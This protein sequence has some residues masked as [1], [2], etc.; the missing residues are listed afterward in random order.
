[1]AADPFLLLYTSGTT[2]SPKAAP[3][4]GHTM[5]SNARL[6]VPEHA[7]GPDDLV[8]SAA[9]FGHLFA[10]YAIELA[11]CAGAASVLL[12][13][14]SPPAFAQAIERH[15]ATHLFAGPAHIAA[16][17]GAGLF[18]RHDLSSVKLSVTSGAA[19]P[20]DLARAYQAKLSN[21]AV[22]QLWGMTELQAGLYT[23]PD[24]GI[25]IAATSAGRPS[26]G[27]EVRIADE[28]GLPLPDGEEGELQVRGPSVFPGYFDNPEAS[29]A[30][31]TADGWFRSGDLARRDTAGHVTLT[32]RTKDVINRGGVKYSPQEVEVL[33]DGHPAVA[34]CAI[35]P[36]PDERLGERACCYAVLKPGATLTLDELCH[37]LLAQGIARHKLPER[38]ELL[39]ALPL[40]ATRKVIKGRLAQKSEAGS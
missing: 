22:C 30:A 23:W 9:P 29:A 5:L 2:A 21:G 6:G 14:F 15:R 35:A 7:I 3:L 1:V 25:E 4:N 16:C 10:L 20:P 13:V 27:T 32:G 19:V 33:V 40:T 12:P 24:D 18:D 39:D 36:I 38:L 26:P 34:Q 37:Y 31:F 11:L 8:L 17:L 28:H